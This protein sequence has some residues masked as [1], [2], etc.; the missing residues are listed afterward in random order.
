MK[1]IHYPGREAGGSGQGV[2]AHKDPGYLTLVMQ[3][4]HSG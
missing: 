3:D 2:G 1:L 4:D